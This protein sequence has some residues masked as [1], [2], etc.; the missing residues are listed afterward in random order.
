VVTVAAGDADRLA[1]GILAW[2][3]TV[4]RHLQEA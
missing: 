2:L 3:A 1:A 4:H